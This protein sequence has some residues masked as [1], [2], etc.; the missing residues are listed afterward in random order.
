MCYKKVH[1]LPL[2]SIKQSRL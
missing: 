2:L 1:L